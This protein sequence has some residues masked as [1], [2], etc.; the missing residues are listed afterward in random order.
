MPYCYWCRH[1]C[2]D[3]YR[4][5]GFNLF[6]CS[7]LC[8]CDCA[9]I[10]CNRGCHGRMDFVLYALFQETGAKKWRFTMKITSIWGR[11]TTLLLIMIVVIVPISLH[12]VTNDMTVVTSTVKPKV[13][14]AG[15]VVGILVIAGGA[16]VIY[17]LYGVCKKVL[18]PNPPPPPPNTNSV[19]KSVMFMEQSSSSSSVTSVAY[20]AT[21]EQSIVGNGV[22]PF[23][24]QCTMSGS[25]NGISII[26]N[27]L[28]VDMDAFMGIQGTS[29][30]EGTGI[31]TNSNPYLNYY[32]SD[33]VAIPPGESL[34]TY[35]GNTFNPGVI[36]T[37][38]GS[39]DS[40][41]KVTLQVSVDM[42]NWQDV[43]VFESQYSQHVFTGTYGEQTLFFRAVLQ[44]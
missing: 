16:F 4:S 33:G 21:P 35:T 18:P 11:I 17:K 39:S 38:N 26:L 36:R 27:A 34:I 37:A 41:R 20:F 28:S 31:P 29:V 7:I 9:G 10:Q 5:E 1:S 24:I 42:T 25:T 32:T 14:V 13:A 2:G 23:C 30:F 12:A 19:T 40:F 6:S 44:E 3:I 22:L 43:V 8:P 15:C